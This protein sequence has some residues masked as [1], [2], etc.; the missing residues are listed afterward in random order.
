MPKHILREDGKGYD[1]V[2]VKVETER[3]GRVQHTVDRSGSC[4][5]ALL[6]NGRPWMYATH[7]LDPSAKKRKKS[8]ENKDDEPDIFVINSKGLSKK[9]TDRLKSFMDCEVEER[10]DKNVICFT[11]EIS[12]KLTRLK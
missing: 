8:A 10:N 6:R 7:P 9:A 1:F 12:D 3:K 11:S 5:A 4:D 2:K